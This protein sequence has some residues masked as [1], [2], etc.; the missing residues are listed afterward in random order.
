MHLYRHLPPSHAGSSDGKQKHPA[1]PSSSSEIEPVG[2]ADA[3]AGWEDG[4]PVRWADLHGTA[5]QHA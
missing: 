3:D 1:A 5:V 4:L 2:G